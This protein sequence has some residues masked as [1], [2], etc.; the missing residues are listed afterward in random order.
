MKPVYDRNGEPLEIL[1]EDF[2]VFSLG[3]YP[4]GMDYSLV[5]E[6]RHFDPGAV[7]GVEGAPAFVQGSGYLSGVQVPLIDL[8]AK[9]GA[10][11]MQPTALSGIV[12][13]TIRGEPVGLVVDSIRGVTIQ[14]PDRIGEA[15]A[16]DPIVPASALLGLG[17]V[18]ADPIVLVDVA[19][20][21]TGEEMAATRARASVI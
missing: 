7:D 11:P 13:A 14:Q 8:G 12:F 15:P 9:L 18:G 4:Y 5:A 1:G 3:G 17:Q 20:L 2:L 19:K 6:L 16:S 21:F 10:A